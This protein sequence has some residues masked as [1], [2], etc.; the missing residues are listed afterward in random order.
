MN[1]QENIEKN[2]NMIVTKEKIDAKF[3]MK[4]HQKLNIKIMIF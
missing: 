1:R 3:K 4:L 2:K